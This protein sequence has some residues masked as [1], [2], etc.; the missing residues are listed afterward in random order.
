VVT[1]NGWHDTDKPYPDV[2]THQL[3]ERQ[4]D[5]SP[6]AVAIVFGDR[7][8]SYRELNE[9]ANQVA[10]FLRKNGVGPEGLVGVSLERC[11]E[12][13]IG[14]LGV[15]KAGGAYVPLDPAYP[16]ER[17]SFMV[18]DAALRILLTERRSKDLFSFSGA[19]TVCLDDDWA[20]IAQESTEKE[21]QHHGDHSLR[22][23]STSPVC[24]VHWAYSKRSIC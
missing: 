20:T 19:T 6:S 13:V 1:L 17:L 22:L 9:R 21:D 11:P 4:V 5:R 2:C 14:L 24:T 12:L 18:G 15:W 7:Q 10:H 23:P 3:F 8:L 16:R